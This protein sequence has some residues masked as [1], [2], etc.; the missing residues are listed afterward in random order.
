MII[1]KLSAVFVTAV[2][3][4]MGLIPTASTSNA[5]TACSTSTADLSILAGDGVCF[6]MSA[7]DSNIAAGGWHLFSIDHDREPAKGYAYDYQDEFS[8]NML[9]YSAY[10]SAKGGDVI[11]Y[12]ISDNEQLVRKSFT[13]SI[14]GVKEIVPK[15]TRKLT[16]NKKAIIKFNNDGTRTIELMAGSFRQAQPDVNAFVDAGDK[17][18]M[19][20]KRK[21]IDFI[22]YVLNDNGSSI[23]RETGKVN[24]RTGKVTIA[25]DYSDMSSS[26]RQSAAR[27]SPRSGWGA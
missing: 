14:E 25:K 6:D 18:I 7:I 23:Y 2:M 3:L 13:V 24:T 11:S 20:T 9:Y 10:P 4:F 22:V 1:R 16:A 17:F 8:P 5:A 15:V 21:S 26:E 19:K 12:V 27:T